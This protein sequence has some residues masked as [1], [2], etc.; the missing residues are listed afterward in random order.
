M[1]ELIA[2]KADACLNEI[3]TCTFFNNE[4]FNQLIKSGRIWIAQPPLY[5][6]TKGSKSTYI[7]NEQ[8]LEDFIISH[9]DILKSIK[10]DS[11][12]FKELYEI[13]KSKFALQRF[14][15]LGEM[16][17]EELW[18]TTLDPKN[19]TL[20]KVNYS[21]VSEKLSMIGNEETSPSAE[22][23]EIFDIL[24]GDDVSK[25]KDFINTNAINVNNLDI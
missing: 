2:D 13:E 3:V 22:D 20:L 19:N 4:P 7:K 11:E 5:K 12:Q 10:K 15:G 25:R 21:S 23:I 9:S 1:T 14:K 16:N 6:M 24:M 8:A 18:N 17:P